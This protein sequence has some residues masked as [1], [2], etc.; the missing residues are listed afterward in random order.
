MLNSCASNLLLGEKI[1][2]FQKL[3]SVPFKKAFSVAVS[4]ASFDTS[5]ACIDQLLRDFFKAIGIQ[6][7]PVPISKTLKGSLRGV[8]C[9]IQSTNSSVSG[10]G[11][12]TFELT[13]REVPKKFVFPTIYCRGSC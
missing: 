10:R 1:S 9:K 11:I 3:I 2:S 7:E 4:K 13:F 6:P 8:F 5:N 12:R